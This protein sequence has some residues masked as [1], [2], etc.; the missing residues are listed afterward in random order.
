MPPTVEARSVNTG[1]PG[2]SC[3]ALLS[4][5][6]PFSVIEVGRVVIGTIHKVEERVRLV[7]RLSSQPGDWPRG[8]YPRVTSGCPYGSPAGH[9]TGAH[10]ADPD[11]R[12]LLPQTPAVRGRGRPAEARPAAVAERRGDGHQPRRYHPPTPVPEAA[13]SPG[14]SLK[15]PHPTRPPAGSRG[16]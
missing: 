1:P 15:T 6:F 13:S 9:E 12:V 8:L 2:K 10:R 16:L 7:L 4:R 3:G 14:A 5:L 11:G